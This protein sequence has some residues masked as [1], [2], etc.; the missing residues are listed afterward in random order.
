ML[1]VVLYL[2]VGAMAPFWNLPAMTEEE[3]QAICVEDFYGES[4][5]EAS[6]ESVAPEPSVD[7]EPSASPE[8]SA[9]AGDAGERGMILES[10]ES[11]WEERIRLIRQAR[12]RIILATF[13]MRPQESTR[14]I[15]A[16]LYERAEAGVQVRIL[17]DGLSG[18]LYMEGDPLFYAVSSHP[19]IEIR[20]YNP[21]NLL[22]PWTT[23]G[24]MH[25][26]YLLVDDWAYILGGRNMFDYFIGD[27]ETAHRSHDREVLVCRQAS[28]S[29]GEQPSGECASGEGVQGQPVKEDWEQAGSWKQLEAYFEEVWDGPYTGVFHDEE[30]LAEREEV[31]EQIQALADR[32]DMLEADYPELFEGDGDYGE[33]T[34]PVRKVTL[35]ANPT[36]IYGKKPVVFETLCRLMEEDGGDVI[37][38]TPYIVLSEEMQERLKSVTET[39][40]SVTILTNSVENGDNFFG[41]SD[42]VRN[43]GKVLDTGVT[44]YE[45]DGG[46]SYHAKSVVIGD[47]LAIVGSYNLDLRSTYVD[48]ELMLVID[49]EELCQE[50]TG[51][52]EELQEDARKAVDE[53]TYETP[54][55]LTVQEVPWWKRLAWE[56]VGRLMIP[57]RVL[58]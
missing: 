55:H 38:H 37:L 57:F 34:L 20:L 14:D 48:T 35:L 6:G 45:Y 21:V 33:R 15:L 16:M 9:P 58:I 49:S 12:E 31:R 27:Y 36:H 54:A 53:D 40:V 32:R 43:K 8:P 11:A 19:N 39:G 51:Y 7:S 42:Y 52:M 3:R 29:A 4:I 28:G 25:D 44:V 10:N 30:A 24:R 13:D 50:L 56:I 23:Q 5:A 46:E 2:I 22:K 17:V 47:R 26:K 18:L 1:A 41:S